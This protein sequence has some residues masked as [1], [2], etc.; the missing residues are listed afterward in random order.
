[1]TTDTT[2]NDKILLEQCIWLSKE[3]IP[4]TLTDECFR[5]ETTNCTEEQ[6]DKL[7]EFESRKTLITN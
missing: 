2:A 7:L 5:V 6:K 3:N 4:F 1:M